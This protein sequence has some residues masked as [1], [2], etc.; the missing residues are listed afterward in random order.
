MTAYNSVDNAAE[1]YRRK[2]QT[3]KYCLEAI[4]AI[5][6]LI[7]VDPNYPQYKEMIEVLKHRLELARYVGD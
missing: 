4:D 3:A 2:E 5:E 1:Y 6:A 7:R